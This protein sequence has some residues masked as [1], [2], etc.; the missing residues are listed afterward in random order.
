VEVDGMA[1]NPQ[2]GLV[3][4]LSLNENIGSS[5][6][7]KIYGATWTAGVE[8][9]A[10]RFNGYDHHAEVPDSDA[11]ALTSEGTIMAW[12][13]AV[14]H[15]PYSGVLHKGEATDFSDEC[16]SLQFWQTTGQVAF[17]LR[18]AAGTYMDLYSTVFLP[19]SLWIHVTATWDGSF[20]RLYING[21]LDNS[22][23]NTVGLARDSDGALIVGAQTATP[24]DVP[25]GHMGFD[26][27]ID[28]I[29]I[30]DRALGAGEI[31][32]RY[33]YHRP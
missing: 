27:V 29:E 4:G 8:G 16:W 25:T 14:S 17:F 19:T 24:I 12:V 11:L 1:T 22:E 26:G 3:L 6:T 33:L 13:H 10:L 20:V 2:T 7:V 31:Y 28:H 23:P 30:Y 15:S 18:N 9:G 21:S 32:D 5:S